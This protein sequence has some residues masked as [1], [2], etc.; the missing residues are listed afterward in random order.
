MSG[1]RIE[2]HG[3]ILLQNV[4]AVLQFKDHLIGT[5]DPVRQIA[6]CRWAAGVPADDELSLQ[7][8]AAVQQVIGVI[9][10]AAYAKLAAAA[11]FQGEKLH[12]VF[13]VGENTEATI[14][15]MVPDMSGGARG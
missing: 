10:L 11:G 9:V 4:P 13:R 6:E 3:D 2:H 5:V 8:R 1:Q 15:E 12:N 14:N 7:A